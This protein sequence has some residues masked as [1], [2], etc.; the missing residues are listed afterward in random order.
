VPH[1]IS[2]WPRPRQPGRSRRARPLVT[3]V[4]CALGVAA[5]SSQPASSG[6]TS[7]STST[8]AGHS[9]SSSTQPA[10]SSTTTTTAGP[11]VEPLEWHSCGSGLRCAF[12][13]VPVSYTTPS[14][15]TIQ[16]AVIELPSTS[17]PSTARDLVVNPGGPGGSGLQ[18]LRSA[19]SYFSSPLRQAFNIVSFDPRGV[20]ESVPV[21]C[22]SATFL[23]QW[24]AFDPVPVT[25]TQINQVIAEQKQFVKNCEASLPRDVLANLSTEVT[26]HD[27]DRLRAALGQ[28]KLDYL[29]FSY[30]TY[31]GTLYANTFPDRV[32]TFVLDGA[33]DPSVSLAN[34]SL[35]QSKGFEVDLH[36]FFAWCATDGSCASQLPSPS[37]DFARIEA[38]TQS[39]RNPIVANLPSVLGGRQQ[40][41][42]SMFSTG[43]ASALYSTNTWPQLGQDLGAA[44]NGNG[45]L[46]ETLALS[47]AGFNT[48]TGA[49]DNSIPAEVAI[50]CL[51]LPPPPLASYPALA[52]QFAQAAPDF[53]AG[54]AWSSL[55]CND[56]PVPATGRP[57]T[58]HL[59]R[60]EH[61]LVV[62]STHDPATPYVWAQALARQLGAELL[63]RTGD[64]HTAY[65]AS[66]CA[67]ND[68]NNYLISQ[69]APPAGTVCPSG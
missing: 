62:G 50:L 21:R 52:K 33:L 40:L 57:M 59:P 24:L 29:G 41:G 65:F 35:V 18:F 37:S 25:K 13:A 43:V 56:W 67:E 15:G 55:P 38:E 12:L 26:A 16:I 61:I 22:G 34:R 66:S 2:Y 69:Q 4:I 54:Q 68:I 10:N 8:N 17:D 53:G 49:A 48:T 3:L 58:V 46:L 9:T 20:G 31:L 1:R 28:P 39:S 42:Y 60:P 45:T 47:Y 6:H 23:R 14:E 7:S 5:C 44:L 19:A 11:P 32:G 27:M 64:G 36:D 30:G 63:T 51:D